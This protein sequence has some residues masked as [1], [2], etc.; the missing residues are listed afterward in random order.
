MQ[1]MR[2][3]KVDSVRA[4]RDGHEFHERWAARKSLQ[5]LLP[6]EGLIGIAMEGLAPADQKK[7]SAETIEIADLTFYYGKAANFQNCKKLRIVQLKY[8]ISRESTEFRCSDAKKTIRKFALAFNRHQ[9]DYGAREVERKLEFE[10]VTNRPMLGSLELGV[11]GIASGIRL[12]G[13]PKKQANQFRKASNLKGKALVTFAK[14]LI[15]TGLAGSLG[16]TNR[17]LKRTVVDWTGATDALSR[18]RLHGITELVRE[19]AG[20][21]GTGRNLIRQTHVI[22]ALEVQDITDLFPC[23]A[24]FP[25]VGKVV[26]RDQL[27]EV[28]S[29]IESLKKPLLIHA[30]GGV[31]KTVFLQSL[32]ATLAKTHETVLFDCFGGGAYRAPEDSRHRPSRGMIHIVNSIAAQGLCDPLLPDNDNIPDLVK[33]FRR[34]LGQAVATLRR[35]SPK[36]QLVIFLDA[37]DN[38]ADQANY[39]KEASFPKVLLES[40]QH[41]GPIDGVKLVVSCRSHRKELAKGGVD[42]QEV[43]LKPFTESEARSYI[44]SRIE[45]LT[46]S[47]FQVA[48]A[49]SG[50]NPRI[51]EY[52]VTSDRGLLDESE[53]DKKIVLKDLLLARLEAA[54]T[55]ARNRG[56]QDAEIHAFLAGLSVLPPPVPIDEYAAAHAMNPSAIVSFANDLI[57]LL[58]RTRHGLM[59]RDE[60]TETLIR[61]RYSADKAALTAVSTNL[62]NQQD[63]SV[64]AAMALPGLLRK[65][66]N[67]ELLFKLAFDERFPASVSSDVGKRNIRYAR[68]RAAT[69]H[70]AARRDNNKLVHLLVELSTVAA[71]NDRATEYILQ[72]PHLVIASQDADAVRRLF[73]S[74]TAWRGTRHARLAIAHCLSGELGDAQRHMI[75]TL[76]WIDHY[77]DQASEP[78][79]RTEGP[80]RLDLASIA[81]VLIAQ[82]QLKEALQF[83]RG[84]KVWSAFEICEQLFPLIRQAT[85]AVPQM[86]SSVAQFIVMLTNEVGIFTAAIAFGDLPAEL[87]RSLIRRLSNSLKAKEKIEFRSAFGRQEEFVLQDGLT[88]ACVAALALGLKEQAAEIFKHVPLEHPSAWSFRDRFNDGQAASF[89]AN[90]A[91][92]AAISNRKVAYKDVLPKEL[93]ADGASIP[94]GL[95]A[96]AFRAEMTKRIEQLARD[97]Q[98]K[99]ETEKRRSSF[100]ETKGELE[101]FLENRHE[102]LVSLAQALEQVFSATGSQRSEMLLQFIATWDEARSVLEKYETGPK[103]N[104]YFD[105]VGR[106]LLELILRTGPT[107]GHDTTDTALRALNKSETL[108]AGEVTKFVRIL[109]KVESLHA[110]AGQLAREARTLS[111]RD[112]DVNSRA[113]NLAALASAILPAS[114]SEATVYFHTGLKQMDSI[115]SGDYQFTGELLAFA[116]ELHGDVLAGRDYHTLT[117]ICELNMYE[118]NKFPWLSFAKAMTRASGMKGLAK[119]GRWSD[120][121]KVSLDVTLLPYLTVLIEENKIKPEHALALLRLSDSV[122]LWVCNTEALTKAILARNYANAQSLIAELCRQFLENNSRVGLGSSAKA[123]AEA[124]ITVGGGESEDAQYLKEAAVQSER[125]RNESNDHANYHGRSDRNVVDPEIRKREIETSRS[126]LLELVA[127]VSPIDEK[128]MLAA[129][130]YFQA[131]GYVYELRGSFYKSLRAKV[132]YNERQQ[133]IKMLA[134]LENLNLYEK[135]REFEACDAEWSNSSSSLESVFKELAIPLI[136]SHSDEFLF[137]DHLST[138][139]LNKIS[140]L[141][142]IPASELTREL[143]VVYAA[144]Q[145]NVAASVWMALAATACV[146]AEPGEGQSAISRLLNSS[147]AQLSESVIDGAW[148]ENLYPTQDSEAEIVAGLIWLQLGSPYTAA[149]WQAAHSV[150]SLARL[151]CWDALD[152]LCKKMPLKSAGS[153]QARELAFYFLHA[154]LWLLIA[155]AR[156]A[157]DEPVAIA[158]YVD[159]LTDTAFEN[160]LPH[161]LARHFA[162]QALL[163]CAQRGALNLEADTILRLQKLNDSPLKGISRKARQ[164]GSDLLYSKRPGSTPEPEERFSLE[165]DFEKSEVQGLTRVFGQPGWVARDAI[166]NWV[167]L[168]DP[169]A[170]SMYEVGGRERHTRD[171]RGI[172]PKFHGYG[173]YLGWHALYMTAAEFLAKYP[174]VTD[175]FDPDSWNDWFRSETLTRADGLWLADGVDNAPLDGTGSILEKGKEGLVLTGSRE[176]I[177]SLIGIVKSI[178]SN[179]VVSGEWQSSDGIGISVASV[180]VPRAKASAL[181][182]KLASTDPAQVW[183]PKFERHENSEE[184]LSEHREGKSEFDAWIVHPDFSPGL[185]KGD[186]LATKLAMERPYIASKIAKQMAIGSSDAFSREWKQT[187][188]E[189]AVTAEAWGSDYV[190]YRDDEAYVGKRLKCSASFLKDILDEYKKALVVLVVLRRYEKSLGDRESRF[191]HT[192]AVVRI[193]S[194]LTFEYFAGAVNRIQKM[195][196]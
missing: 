154:R 129:V 33:A 103:Q 116:G 130:D 50:G 107:F 21:A 14:S 74:K 79:L 106:N 189:T 22:D 17:E 159:L 64:Y 161:V 122:E 194:S 49:R 102:P 18:A 73:E 46:E 92:C 61:E 23:P 24:S 16:T 136:Q 147:A 28:E 138:S 105:V 100:Y 37:I 169:S 30:D 87:E 63:K 11:R 2:R 126:N 4:S 88:H 40:I 77:K 186:R 81:L 29:K 58:E 142:G 32:V 153:F 144:P 62:Y 99:A 123:L 20:H 170:K 98:K 47:E 115:G 36:S 172:D 6:K 155:L 179:V 135:L 43:E 1:K 53:R 145:S 183:L 143:I 157:K 45:K 97:S 113:S 55:D 164:F 165:Y 160:G 70:A 132:K 89:V 150:R 57:P 128:Q 5:L 85:P 137:H 82:K 131:C 48:N 83:L 31:G 10:I 117:N 91:L 52:L 173:E 196:Y 191:S 124:S 41:G 168:V 68:L 180:L 35:G 187:N 182:N 94:D 71:V 166:G 15:L 120:R 156:I 72:N 13:E 108:Y 39:Q 177:C 175:K 65:L 146:A 109:S 7:A 111:D 80:D 114:T 59:F 75:M 174:V 162:G 171:G 67:E 95:D 3:K 176:K 44:T 184:Y 12:V 148:N 178:E 34:R 192:S 9:R 121:D 25:E 38:A 118:A 90:V 60:P 69:S 112:D 167:R 96:K 76:D 149:R 151:G 101:R 66:E 185:D 104:K 8:S 163:A 140:K 195:R 51:L 127:T 119:L 152:A 181:A 19:K 139:D 86:Q 78:H 26:E 141:S 133:Y 134:S 190:A 27:R 54:L 56:Y 93:A 188:G 110:L 42:C 84:W 193:Q 125:L 158:R